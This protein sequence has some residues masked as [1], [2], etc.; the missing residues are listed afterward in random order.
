M[1]GQNSTNC[2]TQ[3][4]ELQDSARYIQDS[5]RHIQD[6]TQHIQEPATKNKLSEKSKP[7]AIRSNEHIQGKA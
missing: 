6:S 4:R 3:C 7:R 1:A 5:T 2:R